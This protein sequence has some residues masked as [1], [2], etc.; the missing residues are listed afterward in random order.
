MPTYS[1]DGPD[2]K[3]YSIDGPE[4]AS[5]DQVIAK[6]KEKQ[7]PAPTPDRGVVDKLFGLTGE[8]YQTWPER[9]V[10]GVAGGVADAAL[11]GAEL[12]KKA[13]TGEYGPTGEGIVD[14]VSTGKPL[15]AAALGVTAAPA[16]KEIAGGVA[17][18]AAKAKQLRADLPSKDEIKQSAQ[19]AYKAVED[20]RLIAS[21]GS[22]G[23]LVSATRAGLDQRLMTDTT[24]PRTFKALEQLQ[25]SGGDIAQIMGV[26][27]RLGEIKPSAGTDHEAALHVKDAIDHY[28]ENLPPGEIVQGDP[29]F[30]QAML[31]H[32]R[33]SWKS[34]SQLDQVE[35]ALEI[36]KHRAAVAGTGANTQNSMRQ[37]IR[38]IL[39]SDK[40]RNLSPKAKEQMENIV[41][42]TAASNAARYAGKFAPS[43]PVSALSTMT[44]ALAGDIAGG[45]GMATAA[46]AAV[47]IPATIAKYLG[48]YL[49]KRQI[50]ELENTIR[51]ESPLGKAASASV[52]R[53]PPGPVS[54][55]LRGATPAL[56]PGGAS[57]LAAPG[58]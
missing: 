33:G 27:Q 58:Q 13:V 20:A 50:Q 40:S 36:G 14:E 17:D 23:G 46:A 38:E 44:A 47:A 29:K 34:Y 43:G 10:R 2:G 54:Q 5:R 4:G 7:T 21:E 42:G 41:M 19:A 25:S 8:R 15:E 12:T 1:I 32:A 45:R 6:I 30:T 22:V 53:E 35:S 51:S 26:R 3:S 55:V 39:D 18:V 49:T 28:V 11:T 31:E 56:V 52:N 24:A 37:R 16:A 57:S 48:T 9:T